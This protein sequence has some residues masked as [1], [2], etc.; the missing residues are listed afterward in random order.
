MKT[1]TKFDQPDHATKV[2]SFDIQI[3]ITSKDLGVEVRDAFN[4]AKSSGR[5][6]TIYFSGMAAGDK[7]GYPPKSGHNLGSDCHA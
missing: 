2:K 4:L 1:A 6:L 7:L 5:E 3:P